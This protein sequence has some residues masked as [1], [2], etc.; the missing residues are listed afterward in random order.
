M[1]SSASPP[2]SLLL[3][4]GRL[5]FIGQSHTEVSSGS[6]HPSFNIHTSLTLLIRPAEPHT[7]AQN[8]PQP[9]VPKETPLAELLAPAGMIFLS[10]MDQRQHLGLATASPWI[11]SWYF[12]MM[13]NTFHSLAEAMLSSR[14]MRDMYEGTHTDTPTPRHTPSFYQGPRWEEVYDIA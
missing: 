3:L 12:K 6:F 4:G 7:E 5:W 10:S 1:H 13:R 9:L 8:N 14:E 2:F 11:F